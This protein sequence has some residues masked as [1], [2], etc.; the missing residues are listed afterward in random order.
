MRNLIILGPLLWS[1]IASAQMMPVGSFPQGVVTGGGGY[2]GPGDI[3]S[4]AVAFYGVRAYSAAIA[5]AGTQQIFALRRSSD[6]AT[7]TAI[8]A[9]NGT[10][11]LTVGTPC[12]GT[13]PTGTTGATTV[14]AWLTSTTAGVSTRYDQSGN[15]RNQ[16]QA[17][18]GSQPQLLL[19]GFGPNS[20]PALQFTSQFISV[21]VASNLYSQPFTETAEAERSSNFTTQMNFSTSA[22]GTTD[23]YYTT[24]TNTTQLYAG[25]ASASVTASDSAA[26]AIQGIFNGASSSETVDGTTTSGLNPGTNKI[27]LDITTGGNAVGSGLCNVCIIGESGLWP[28]GFSGGNLSSMHSNM[29]TYYGSP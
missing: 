24:S 6:N 10:V 8:I 21:S 28:S 22:A 2:T 14:T 4:G 1:A 29:A 26:H 15:G 27:S 23:M 5:A 18:A 11:D 19:S 17:T 20:K 25:A 13:G 12:L 7:C 16:T 3:V 9:T